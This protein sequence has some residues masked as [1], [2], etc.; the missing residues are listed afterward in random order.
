[1]PNRRY[2]GKTAT[3][4]GQRG[5]AYLLDMY[6]GNMKKMLIVRPQHLRPQ[7]DATAQ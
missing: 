3:V 2:Q 5:R 1:M 7:T 6:D 4:T